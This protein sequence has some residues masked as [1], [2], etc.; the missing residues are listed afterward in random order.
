MSVL[1]RFLHEVPSVLKIEGAFFAAEVA[2]FLF[3]AFSPPLKAFHV[4]DLVDPACDP[5]RASIPF[6]PKLFPLLFFRRSAPKSPTRPL[7]EA[8][9]E[10]EL[11][12]EQP[13]LPRDGRRGPF[14]FRP[15]AGDLNMVAFFFWR[16]SWRRPLF[17]IFSTAW[18]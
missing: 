14:F 4:D 15:C 8:S 11:N 12:G 5:C 9:L 2:A 10:P 1:S 3:L 13:R 17:M 18:P 6:P 7:V 16:S